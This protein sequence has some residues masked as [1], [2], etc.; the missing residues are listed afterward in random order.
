MIVPF[1]GWT[2][3][4]PDLASPGDIDAS[5]VIPY[6]GGYRPSPGMSAVVSALDARCRGAAAVTDEAGNAAII[7]ADSAKI[8]RNSGS[9]FSDVSKSGGYSRA[10]DSRVEFHLYG[11][12]VV[13]TDFDSAV[14]A[15]NLS[16]GNFADLI[17]GTYKPKARTAAVVG[18]FLMLG[19]TNDD[20]DGQKPSRCWWS[21]FRDITSFDPSAS[22]QSDFEDISDGGWVQRLVGLDNS[23]LVVQERQIVRARFVGPPFFFDFSEVVDKQRGTPIP[24][25]IASRGRLMFGISEE[26]FFV[27]EAGASRSIGD[28]KADREFWSQIATAHFSRVSAAIDDQNKCYV[29]AFPGTGNTNGLPNRR[30][31][32]HWPSG[33]FGYDPTELEWVFNSLT[34]GYTLDELDAI[35]AQLE[36]LPYPLDSRAWTGGRAVLGGFN[37]SHAACTFTGANAAASITTK[38]VSLGGGRRVRCRRAFPLVDTSSATLAT[39]GRLNESGTATFQT[40]RAMTSEG[41][42]PINVKARYHSFKLQVP[43]GTSWTFARGIQ[44]DDYGD[45]KKRGRR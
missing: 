38:E 4:Q 32:Y 37:T 19:N 33:R 8:Y 25:S 29:V 28:G 9:S 7:A 6:E 44:M 20:T 15:A 17:T 35:S 1:D 43:Q 26:G 13:S 27:N 11:T 23:V 39:A 16:G 36:N 42:C 30:F 2:P 5:G 3:D 12:K 31:F 41:H 14:Q 10:D 40:A 24:G 21:A 45:V 18:G 22:T 34:L